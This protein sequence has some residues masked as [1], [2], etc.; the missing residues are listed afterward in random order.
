MSVRSSSYGAVRLAIHPCG[1]PHGILAKPNKKPF[2]PPVWD[3]RL[4][5]VNMIKD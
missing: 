2:V 5:H 3:K 1:E 4:V